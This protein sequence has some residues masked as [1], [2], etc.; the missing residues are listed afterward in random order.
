MRKANLAAI[1]NG[2]TPVNRDVITASDI[3]AF[4]NELDYDYTSTWLDN[5]FNIL[6]K[7]HPDLTIEQVVEAAGKADDTKPL[8]AE[9]E[10]HIK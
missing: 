4:N 6:K 3:T 9:I 7:T 2:Q 8:I 1:K 10:K 5:T